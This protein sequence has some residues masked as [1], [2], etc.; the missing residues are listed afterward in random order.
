MACD[1]HKRGSH[2]IEPA[3]K[4]CSRRPRPGER[5]E[6]EAPEAST[7]SR[8]ACHFGAH[9]RPKIAGFVSAPPLKDARRV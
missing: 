1:R 2:R 9:T 8:I 7:F 5:T 3:R 6:Q 4:E